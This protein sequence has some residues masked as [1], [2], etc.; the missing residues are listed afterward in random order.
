MSRFIAYSS[1]LSGP[2]RHG[3]SI[4]RMH[5]PL[6]WSGP[7]SFNVA[8]TC[9]GHGPKTT[10][11]F[12]CLTGKNSKKPLF[13]PS[14]DQNTT[15]Q[16]ADSIRFRHKFRYGAEQRNFGGLSGELNDRT[17]ELQRNFSV[18]SISWRSPRLFKTDRTPSPSRHRLR[19][20]PEAGGARRRAPQL[21][22]R[23]DLSVVVLAAAVTVF[24]RGAQ[25]VLV[26][27]KRWLANT[28]RVPAAW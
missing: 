25:V 21:P 28:L 12:R 19:H 23:L 14:T 11:G 8:K 6:P 16:V 1:A 18:R 5:G 3:S 4:A 13:R 7:P 9:L 24:D 15:L 26:Q 17:A 22:P 2:P 27:P 20:R 10:T